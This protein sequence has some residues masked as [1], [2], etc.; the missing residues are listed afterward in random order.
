ML[1]AMGDFADPTVNVET[2]SLT[3][4]QD[5][6]SWQLCGSDIKSL[7]KTFLVTGLSVREFSIR[8][9]I[10]YSTMKTLRA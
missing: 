8:H 10:P 6:S 1:A 2:L 9:L 3:R 7:C 5:L 4:F